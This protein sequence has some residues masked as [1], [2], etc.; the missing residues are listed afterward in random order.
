MIQSFYVA[1]KID[2]VTILQKR[3]KELRNVDTK[4]IEWYEPSDNSNS[5]RY[6]IEFVQKILRKEKINDYLEYTEQ[7]K[8]QSKK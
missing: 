6:S 7:S 8:K 3:V 2:K 4:N 5:F 1:N